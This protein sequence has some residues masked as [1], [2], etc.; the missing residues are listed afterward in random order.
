MQTNKGFTL[1]EGFLFLAIA[2]IIGFTGWYVW[3]SK[4]KT[5]NSYESSAQSTTNLPTYISIKTFEECKKAAGSKLLETYPEQCVTVAG[6]TFTGP[7]TQGKKF[8]DIKEWLAGIP[9]TDPSDGYY[10]KLS[11]YQTDGKSSDIT[12]YSKKADAII[13]PKGTS[14]RG[15]YI[16]Y[17]LRLLTNDPSWKNPDKVSPLFSKVKSIGGYTYALTTKKEYGP[18][19]FDRGDAKTGYV[20]DR[21]TEDK[22]ETVVD[23]FVKDYGSIDAE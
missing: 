7:L 3:Q 21:I 18:Q 19:C 12:V 1:I 13:G 20:A 14:C 6:K 15:E 5:N 23:R 2:G 22:F 17:I 10:Y 8:L 9:L 16:A 11:D 4:D